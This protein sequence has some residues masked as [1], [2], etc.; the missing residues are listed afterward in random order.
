MNQQVTTFKSLN[1]QTQRF[2][3]HHIE[4]GWKGKPTPKFTEQVIKWEKEMFVG[5]RA[6]LVDDVVI[7]AKPAFNLY[8]IFDEMQ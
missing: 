1:R 8:H 3:H 4:N 2:E 7:L 6:W 5:Q